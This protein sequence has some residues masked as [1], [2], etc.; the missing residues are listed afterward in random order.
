MKNVHIIGIR[1]RTKLTKDILPAEFM[2]SYLVLIGFCVVA[3][4]LQRMMDIPRL[5]EAEQK[6]QGRPLAEIARQ[7]AFIVA[8]HS[9]MIGY[10]VMNLLMAATP[11]GA[12]ANAG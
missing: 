2:G 8:V 5:T 4:I 10:G 12:T 7:P 11:A 3:L 9:G 6:D 1:S